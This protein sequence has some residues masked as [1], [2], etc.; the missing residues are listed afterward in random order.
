VRDL[1]SSLLILALVVASATA[2]AQG[3]SDADRAA[4]RELYVQ[5]VELQQAGRFTEALDRFNRAQAVFSAP[6]HLLHIAECEA[7]L[8]K[9]VESAETYRTLVRTPLPAGAPQAFVQAQQQAGTELTQVEPRLPSIRVVVRPENLQGLQIQVDGQ[10][11]STALVGVQRPTD[12]GDHTV[13]VYAPGY[14][15]ANQ[16]IA[17]QERENRDVTV[18]LQASSGIVYGGAPPYPPAVQPAQPAPQYAPAPAPYGPPEARRPAAGGFMLGADLGVLIPGGNTGTIGGSDTSVSSFASTGGAVGINAGFRFVRRLYLGI[19]IQHGFLGSGSGAT[20]SSSTN[21]YALDFAYLSNPD[22]VVGFYA[23][24][25]VGY[26]TLTSGESSTTFKGGDVS[27]GIG[28][29]IHVGEWVR[30]IP[31]VSVSGGQFDSASCNASNSSACAG[32]NNVTISD[33][34]A[35]SFVFIGVT[36]MVDFARKR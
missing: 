3:I 12:P 36:G 25:G 31:K 15:R 14:A 6:T 28:M 35:H 26:R 7:S 13:T 18:A 11:M 23:E 19:D 16:K 24:L 2:Q 20:S 17:L 33:T 32:S 21:L 5:G 22:G 1:S 27:L 8:G 4:A 10:P 34:D 29:H 9:L 30:L